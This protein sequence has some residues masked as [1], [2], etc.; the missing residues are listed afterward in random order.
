MKTV[1][2]TQAE[3]DKFKAQAE[4]ITRLEKEKKH[5]LEQISLLTR[6]RYAPKSERTVYL[7]QLSL[8]NLF[9]EAEVFSD[10]TQEEPTLE[11]VIQI[12]AHRR[13]KKKSVKEGLPEN[14][15]VIER[16]H[17]VDE[18]GRVC[19]HCSAHME[20]IGTKVRTQLGLAPAKVFKIQD[21]CHV[22][23]C[24]ACDKEAEPVTVTERLLRY[25]MNCQLGHCTPTTKSLF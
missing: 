9:D 6:A 12:P 1:R 19:P 16:H 11:E 2:I 3:Y 25:S 20:E 17:Y 4:Y 8:D 14:I 15:P 10:P 23:A 7:N 5:L 22:Y 18:E 21:I 13:K 24:K